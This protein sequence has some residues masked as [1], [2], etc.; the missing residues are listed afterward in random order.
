MSQDERDHDHDQEPQRE[1]IKLDGSAGVGDRARLT[2]ITRDPVDGDREE[3]FLIPLALL[4][5]GTLNVCM[6]Y[7]FIM[8]YKVVRQ[9][10]PQ[11]DR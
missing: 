9:D 11:E 2:L 4:N 5:M 7:N 8:G 1:M 10:K 6:Q 3:T